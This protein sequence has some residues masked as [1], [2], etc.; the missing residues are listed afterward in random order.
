MKWVFRILGAIL[1]SAVV[2]LS[3]MLVGGVLLL[4][5][6]TEERQAIGLGEADIEARRADLVSL[7]LARILRVVAPDATVAALARVSPPGTSE[8]DLRLALEAVA[9]GEVARGFSAAQQS[10]ERGELRQMPV[11][12]E[13]PRGLRA[14]SGAKFLRP[15]E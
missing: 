2:F 10:P 13:A 15:P 4:D 5:P 7:R 3:I 8:S 6:T 9:S 1:R 14:I 12:S 11:Q